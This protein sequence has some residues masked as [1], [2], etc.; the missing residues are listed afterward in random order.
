MDIEATLR[1]TASSRPAVVVTGC[2][3]TGK[4]GLLM[5][6][7]LRGW[8]RY[9]AQRRRAS[10]APRRYSSRRRNQPAVEVKLV[11]AGKNSLASSGGT[12]AR[13][14]RNQVSEPSLDRRIWNS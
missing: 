3:Q 7:T 2:R 8:R 9:P 5:G 4:T 13:S 12:K 11:P 6:G 14:R 10:T 1:E